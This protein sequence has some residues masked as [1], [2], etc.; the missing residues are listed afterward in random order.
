MSSIWA[1]R[2]LV[3]IEIPAADV[4]DGHL[5]RDVIQWM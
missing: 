5:V 2:S 1:K 3:R 4:D